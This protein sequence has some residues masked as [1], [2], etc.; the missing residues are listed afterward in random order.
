M[1]QVF[2][3]AGGKALT[4]RND[5]AMGAAAIDNRQTSTRRQVGR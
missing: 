1:F 2:A 4:R 3:P 5:P